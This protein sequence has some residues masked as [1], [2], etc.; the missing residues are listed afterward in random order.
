MVPMPKSKMSHK[1]EKMSLCAICERKR[2]SEHFCQYH[3][4]AF[5]NLKEKYEIWKLRYGSLSWKDY[6]KK[7][8]ELEQNG[9]W[10]KEVARYLLKLN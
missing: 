4:K 2:T 3:D 5:K 10:V 8:I 9:I 1:S 7:Q 6:L